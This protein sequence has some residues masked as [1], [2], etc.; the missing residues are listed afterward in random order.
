M[1]CTACSMLTCIH[2]ATLAA[3]CYQQYIVTRVGLAA[4]VYMQLMGQ[5]PQYTSVTRT[6]Q[7]NHLKKQPSKY[8]CIQV[9][10]SENRHDV[11]NYQNMQPPILARKQYPSLLQHATVSTCHVE[12]CMQTMMSASMH[13]HNNMM[14]PP[15][16]SGGI[17]SSQHLLHT[18]DQ[19]QQH[20]RYPAAHKHHR[21]H[22][23]ALG[24]GR[25]SNC[26]QSQPKACHHGH[27]NDIHSVRCT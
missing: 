26:C 9:F 2:H 21:H 8:T 1:H 23:C 10:M 24:S 18:R 27:M 22:D 20:T 11:C 17:T 3:A 13:R 15:A 25:P 16:A 12:T 5:M 6:P 14:Q 19:L 4:G 7:P